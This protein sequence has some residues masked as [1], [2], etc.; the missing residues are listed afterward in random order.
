MHEKNSFFCW[1]ILFSRSK[2]WLHSRGV[3][4][5]IT[6]CN[7]NSLLLLV[8]MLTAM[9]Y[10][11]TQN[12]TNFWKHAED[13]QIISV[14]HTTTRKTCRIHSRLLQ[15]FEYLG[16]FVRGCGHLIAECPIKQA[17]LGTDCYAYMSL[18]HTSHDQTFKP[19]WLF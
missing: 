9:W 1:L 5:V 18:E 16:P 6:D 15:F 17:L 2:S 12:H 3:T 13:I 4:F 7:I 14:Q 11:P 10:R 19:D 8:E